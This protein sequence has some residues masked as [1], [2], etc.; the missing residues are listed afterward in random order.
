MTPIGFVM[1]S[2]N[3]Q[4]RCDTSYT[5]FRMRFRILPMEAAASS[6]F[7]S[8]GFFFLNR[9]VINLIGPPKAL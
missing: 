5:S 1:M 3:S 7:S 9:F 2:E 6:F 4:K 8:A